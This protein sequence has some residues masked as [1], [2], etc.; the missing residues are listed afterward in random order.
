MNNLGIIYSSSDF[1]AVITR[2][3]N[4]NDRTLIGFTF[5]IAPINLLT[6]LITNNLNGFINQINEQKDFAIEAIYLDTNN[7]TLRPEPLSIDAEGFSL[8]NNT[9]NSMERLNDSNNPWITYLQSADLASSGY[10]FW[11]SSIEFVFFGKAQIESIMMHSTSIYVSGS[12]INYGVGSLEGGLTT[13]GNASFPSLK[14]EGLQQNNRGT[15]VPNVV[16]GH[17]CPP[18]WGNGDV[19]LSIGLSLSIPNFNWA[20]QWGDFCQTTID[21]RKRELEAIQNAQAR[22]LEAFTRLDPK[23]HIKKTKE[24]PRK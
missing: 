14:A 12:E 21:R 6:A 7:M 13:T 4:T 3:E 22:T 10:Q 2:Y 8:R 11:N 5:Q 1:Q 19:F 20:A 23:Q 9:N 17:P 24:D 16:F 15:Y 18:I